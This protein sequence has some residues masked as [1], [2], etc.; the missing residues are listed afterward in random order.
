LKF[1]AGSLDILPLRPDHDRAAFDCGN[2]NLDRYIRQQA[3]Q[4]VAR[5]VARVFVAIA[6]ENDSRILGYYT[7]GAT[8]IA[9]KDLPQDVERRLPRLPVPAALIGRLAVDRTVAGHGL[10]KILLADAL[11]K[12]E[13]ASESLA[14]AAL[15]VDPIDD[16]ARAFYRAF[17]FRDALG[18]HNQMFLMRRVGKTV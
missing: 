8:S 5:G 2:Q 3:R 18:S 16:A 6:A 11:L 12:S 4:D 14:V 13:V 1:E 15:V 17:G 9:P 10:G 7:L